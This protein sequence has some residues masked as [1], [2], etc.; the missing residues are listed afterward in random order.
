ML[1]HFW[2]FWGHRRTLEAAGN[3]ALPGKTS[4][5]PALAPPKALAD[6]CLAEG[7]AGEAGGVWPLAAAL[8]TLA[9]LALV[10]PGPVLYGAA[11]TVVPVVVRCLDR[12]SL[13]IP[14]VLSKCS[15][16]HS[17]STCVNP[18]ISLSGTWWRSAERK[19]GP[20]RVGDG[21]RSRSL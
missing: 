17:A 21:R 1:N 10:G 8:A 15:T 5:A 7:L 11:V 14:S 9:T 4:A 18:A 2:A 19:A 16:A 13:V 6:K 3:L 20:T 12:S